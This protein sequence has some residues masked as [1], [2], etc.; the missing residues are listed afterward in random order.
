M[1]LAGVPLIRLMRHRNR[2]S[3]GLVFLA[4]AMPHTMVPLA[5]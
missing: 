4:L 3:R 5:I 1:N 2:C